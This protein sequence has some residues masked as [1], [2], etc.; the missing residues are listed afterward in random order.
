MGRATRGVKGIR[1]RKGDLV[2]GLICIAADRA[3]QIALLTACEHGY[4]KRTPIADYSLQKRGGLGI[5]N[6]KT[7]KRNGK[8]VAAH[9]VE[10]TD[11]VMMITSGGMMVRTRAADVSSIGRNTQGVRLIRPKADQTL[12]ALARLPRSETGEQAE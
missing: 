1:I 6:I 12:V 2:V 8:V 10:E 3:E 11:E 9:G 5:V 7:T 4:G